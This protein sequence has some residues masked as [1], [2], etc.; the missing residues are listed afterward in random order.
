VTQP[1]VNMLGFCII[2]NRFVE[3]VRWQRTEAPEQ[4]NEAKAAS[5]RVFPPV[6][7][8]D[9]VAKRND[10]PP[11]NFEDALRELE[12]ILADIEGG[13]I[14]LEES[15]AKYERGNFLIQHCRTI[16]GA[17]EKHIEKLSKAPDGSLQSEPMTSEAQDDSGS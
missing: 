1:I 7:Y 17:A 4:S 5:H 16:L 15:L 2:D 11:K 6:L 13:Q 9:A 8:T 3:R 10:T 12:Q 14:G